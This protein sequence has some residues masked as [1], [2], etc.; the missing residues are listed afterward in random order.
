L[1]FGISLV[2]EL[3]FFFPGGQKI[4]LCELQHFAVAVLFLSILNRVS[5]MPLNVLHGVWFAKMVVS[6]LHTGQDSN[7]PAARPYHNQIK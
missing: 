7:G 6:G 1:I 5:E 2:S 4:F 3:L